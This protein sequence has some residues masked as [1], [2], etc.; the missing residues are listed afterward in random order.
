LSLSAGTETTDNTQLTTDNVLRTFRSIKIDNEEIEFTEGF[1]DLHT[2]VYEKTLVGKG[3]GI[4]EARNSIELVYKLRN[5]K[6]DSQ[7]D[8]DKQHHFLMKRENF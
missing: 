8:R 7:T 3:F 4:E 6:V 5:E 2:K 1:T